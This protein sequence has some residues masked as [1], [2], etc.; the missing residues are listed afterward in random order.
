MKGKLVVIIIQT[1]CN[2]NNNNSLI[3]IQSALES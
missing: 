3:A 2:A 1:Y